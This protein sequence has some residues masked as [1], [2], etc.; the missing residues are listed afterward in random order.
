MEKREKLYAREHRKM[1]D[2]SGGILNELID[3]VYIV[4]DGE[5]AVDPGGGMSLV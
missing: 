1:T 3:Y 2:G 4:R 5:C